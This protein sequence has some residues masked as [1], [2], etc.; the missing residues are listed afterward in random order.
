ML[1]DA[2]YLTITHH[3]STGT[4]PGHSIA[5]HLYN[6][7]E[8]PVKLTHMVDNI[9]FDAASGSIFAGGMPLVA[10]ASTSF[11]RPPQRLSRSCAPP[12]RPFTP[13]SHQPP[14]LSYQPPFLSCL[15]IYK[16]LGHEK[17]HSIVVPGLLL[18]FALCPLPFA[19]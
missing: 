6:T 8:G 7:Q 14:S 10:Y 4:A 9:E 13:P 5:R 15:Q 3:Y 16:V 2:A 11:S 1:Y 19:L 12:S 17:D 18:L